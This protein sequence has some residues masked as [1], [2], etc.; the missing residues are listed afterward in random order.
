MLDNQ[1]YKQAHACTRL[2]SRARKYAHAHT[3]KCNTYCF[4]M[5]TMIRESASVLCYTY[6][7]CIV[8]QKQYS[9]RIP[10]VTPH[11]NS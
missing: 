9:P 5:A 7:V 3:E 6:I 8:E 10:E 4:S 2:R 11:S 1:D